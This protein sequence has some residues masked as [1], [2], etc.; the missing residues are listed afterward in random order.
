MIDYR[1]SIPVVSTFLAPL[2]TL[3]FFRSHT[4]KKLTRPVRP[5]APFW[6]RFAHV[7][8]FARNTWQTLASPLPPRALKSRC[9]SAHFHAN[10]LGGVRGIHEQFCSRASG[11][12]ATSLPHYPASLL[13][14]ADA[15]LL[16]RNV[17]S[18][19][20]SMLRSPFRMLEAARRT[21][22][23]YQPEASAP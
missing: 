6:A 23:H 15:R 12:I 8:L 11:S 4:H 14:D 2:K 7:V 1:T 5:A 19:K 18:T 13:H 10:S 20:G 3:R 16:D 17:Q 22:F 9:D 21:S